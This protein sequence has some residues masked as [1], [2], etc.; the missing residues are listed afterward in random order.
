VRF[1][2]K[3]VNDVVVLSSPGMIA[4]P[5]DS[6]TPGGA[7]TWSRRAA[8]SPEVTRCPLLRPPLTRAGKDSRN[9]DGEETGIPPLIADMHS[10]GGAKG[11]VR[12][13]WQRFSEFPAPWHR[14]VPL[15]HPAGN[16]NRRV[17]S[18]SLPEFP[19]LPIWGPPPNPPSA[20]ATNGPRERAG[21]QKFLR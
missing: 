9:F 17:V 20:L 4:W 10:P 3:P 19:I 14:C 6:G 15:Q 12:S 21:D 8:P 5:V 11:T 7:P 13:G 2:V 1:F 18:L 16:A